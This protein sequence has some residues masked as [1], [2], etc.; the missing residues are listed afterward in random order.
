MGP[1][2]ERWRLGQTFV[3]LGVAIRAFVSAHEA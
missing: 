2:D 1:G 3:A